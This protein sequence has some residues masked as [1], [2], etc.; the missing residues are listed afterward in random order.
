VIGLFGGAF[1]PP[2]NGHGALLRTAREALG[3]DGAVVVVAARPGHKPVETPAPVRLALTRAA[4]PGETVVLDEHER[5]IDMLRDH[6]E[7]EGAAFLLGADEFA[8]FLGWKEPEEV[9]ELVSLG[10]AT[11]PGYPRETLDGVLECL[12]RPERV[13]FFDLEPLPIA[14][15]ELRARLDRGEDVHE[16]VPPAVWGLLERDALYGLPHGYTGAA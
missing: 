14:S 4:F 10:V 11:R 15:S 8:G 13:T 5:T 1:D 12:E 2:H 9:L 7:W 6:P 3:L 16:L